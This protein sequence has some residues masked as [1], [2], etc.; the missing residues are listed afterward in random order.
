LKAIFVLYLALFHLAM[1]SYASKTSEE[2]L[3]QIAKAAD[4]STKVNLLNKYAFEY[5]AKNFDSSKVYAENALALARQLKYK[6]GIAESLKNIGTANWNKGFF[7][8]AKAL[9]HQSLAIYEEIK[10]TNGIGRLYNNLGLIELTQ[11]EFAV[12]IDYFK[13]SIIFNKATMDTFMLCNAYYNIAISHFYLKDYTKAITNHYKSIEYADVINSEV[14]L[15]QNYGSLGAS[16]TFLKNYE[17]A[18]ENL[19]QALS[20]CLRL[21]LKRELAH[22][23]NLLAHYYLEVHDYKMAIECAEKSA[24]IADSL[25]SLINIYEANKLLADAWSKLGNFEKA[26]KY[27]SLSV[28]KFVKLTNEQNSQIIANISAKYDYDKKLKAIEH[29]KADAEQNIHTRNIIIAVV[30]FFTLFA[31]VLAALLYRNNRER[32]KNNLLLMEQKNSIDEQNKQLEAMN[33]ELNELNTTKDKFFSIIAHDL[34]NPI[35]NLHSVA[36]IIHEDYDI[37]SEDEK[38]EYVSLM[39]NSSKHIY[40]LLENLLTWSRS[41]RG[42]IVVNPVESELDVLLHTTI[43]GAAAAAANKGIEVVSHIMPN[44][45]V[46]TDINLINTIVRNILSN[47]IKF[48]PNGGKIELSS[49]LKPKFVTLKIRDNGVGMDDEKIGTLFI[50][51]ENQS[52]PGTNEEKGTGLGLIICK[53][54]A[55]K[56]GGDIAVKSRQGEGTEFTLTVPL[57]RQ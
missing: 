33:A 31:F 18:Y 54:F 42:Q 38:K 48:T 16:Y 15:A 9:Y 32:R 40:S 49:E 36:Q 14:I 30:S 34:K 8:E 47:A 17:S 27:Q 4:D 20:I 51:G 39:E 46:L 45:K 53:E 19:N 3:F 43:Q 26:Y 7:A 28:E 6:K 21:D 23:Y 13:Q 56:N 41:Q 55:N 5:R 1:V 24:L 11:N 44:T 22:I 37:M 35:Y 10:D 25:N 57:L 52:T 12:A 29:E 50:T 2:I